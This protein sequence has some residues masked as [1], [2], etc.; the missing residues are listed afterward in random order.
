LTFFCIFKAINVV[1]LKKNSKNIEVLLKNAFFGQIIFKFMV[2]R[3]SFLLVTMCSNRKI[4]IRNAVPL[5]PEHIPKASQALVTN[6]WI[7]LVKGEKILKPAHEMY[8]GRGFK[9][10]LLSVQGDV[11]KL[12][13]I[14]A[15]MGLICAETRI[16]FYNLTVV[17]KSLSSIQQRVNNQEFDIS[18]WWRNLNCRLR[19]G[20]G[21]A[22]LV[23]GNPGILIV[24]SMSNTYAS[25]VLDDILKLNAEE[26][27]CLRLVGSVNRSMLPKTLHPYVMPY[28]SQFD[29]PESP[30]PGTRSDYSQRTTRHFL[31]NVL[32]LNSKGTALEHS[33][34]VYD[35]ICKLPISAPYNRIRVDDDE[36]KRVIYKRWKDSGGSCINMLRLLRDDEKISCEQ[37]RFSR[38][39]QSVKISILYDKR[40][41]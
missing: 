16:P 41:R 26:M 10:S 6:S 31:E 3:T 22:E 27:T 9:E 38:L 23:R 19:Q 20:Y 18:D 8:G 12:W 24:I 14:S 37:S 25:L 4:G 11:S 15:G 36:I 1:F 2:G 17:E 32:R 28:N 21:L 35:I 30:L 13:I 39:F 29:G 7:A 33:E 34:Q 5:N 40:K